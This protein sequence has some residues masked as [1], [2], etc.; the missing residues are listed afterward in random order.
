MT[1]LATYVCPA[2]APSKVTTMLLDDGEDHAL[3][4]ELHAAELQASLHTA[5][6]QAS[7]DREAA[8]AKDL[9]KV[10]AANAELQTKLQKV[11]ASMKSA[12][13]TAREALIEMA[14]Q[15]AKLVQAFVDKKRE[16]KQLKV[17]VAE[18]HSC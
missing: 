18:Q 6:L 11:T 9:G 8:L 10:K 17:S 4:T 16:C 13:V 15:N 1:F 2:C 7:H 5:E 12:K 3:A 14:D